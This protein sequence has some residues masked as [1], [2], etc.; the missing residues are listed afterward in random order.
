MYNMAKPED[1]W[2]VIYEESQKPESVSKTT[3]YHYVCNGSGICNPIF[4]Y[5]FKSRILLQEY[6]IETDSGK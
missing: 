3:A 5:Y 1:S 4:Y 2:E 6:D